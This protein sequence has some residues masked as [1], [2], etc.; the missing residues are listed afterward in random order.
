MKVHKKVVIDGYS[1]IP[2]FEE[3]DLLIDNK[4]LLSEEVTIFQ[5]PADKNKQNFNKVWYTGRLL[6]DDVKL[7]KNF[8]ILSDDFFKY[9]WDKFKLRCDSIIYR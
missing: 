9:L 7:N 2:N 6:R 5:N 8:A 4:D 3:C 1:S